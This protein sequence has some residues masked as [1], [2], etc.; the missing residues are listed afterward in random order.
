MIG[1]NGAGKSTIMKLLIGLIKPN[2]G[3]IIFDGKNIKDVE[4][5]ILSNKIS[6]VLQNPEEMFIK[7]SIKNDIMY[8]MK[9]RGV[10]EY[11][12]KSNYLLERFRLSKYQD[13]DGRLLSG[14]QMRRA[15]LAIGIALNPEILLLDEPTANLDIATRQEIKQTLLD[16]REITKTVMIATHDM[17]LVCDW[18]DRVIVLY[19][20][21][22]LADGKVEDIFKNEL[23]KE[24]VGIIPPQ[25]ERMAQ[26][27]GFTDNCFTIERFVAH[28]GGIYE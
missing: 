25:I 20:G 16:L 1:S 3:D 12:E 6:L 27:L 10:K 26:K 21:Q 7:D 2:D 9:E 17:Q 22:V 11:K 14:G 18:A 5:E 19:K 4:P 23:V 13:K 8:A 24:K 28:F 15:S